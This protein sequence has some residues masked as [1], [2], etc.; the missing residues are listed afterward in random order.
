MRAGSVQVRA[1]LIR[2]MAN[3]RLQPCVWPTSATGR[4]QK[5]RI[6]GRCCSFITR[7]MTVLDP[8][9]ALYVVVV[10]VLGI[11]LEVVIAAVIGEAS[12]TVP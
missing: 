3:T 11:G 10:R 9:C 6:D 1:L 8:E 5:L 7:Y 2:R 12:N 4:A